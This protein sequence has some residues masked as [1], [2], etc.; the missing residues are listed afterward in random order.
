MTDK[1]Q[2]PLSDAELEYLRTI[3]EKDKRWKWLA[4]VLRNTAAYLAAVIGGAF[5]LWES[6]GKLVK[7]LAK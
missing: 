2:D 1:K 5:L 7:A 6:L 4:V 3:I